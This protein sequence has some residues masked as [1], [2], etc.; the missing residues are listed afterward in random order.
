MTFESGEPIMKTCF[1]VTIATALFA[2]AGTISAP[3]QIDMGLDF[4]TSFPFYAQNTKLPPGSY[5]VTQ[6][7]IDANELLIESAD[8]RYSVYVDFIPTRSEQS[9]KQSDVTFHKYSNVDYLN[10][11]WVEGQRYGMKIEPTKAERKAAA[12]SKPTEHNVPGTK[13]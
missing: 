3:A 4:T 5:R 9:H 12:S 8:S 10:R 2:C 11:I 13:H 7:D 1:T 6:A